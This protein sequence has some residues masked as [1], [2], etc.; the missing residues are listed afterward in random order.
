MPLKSPELF[1]CMLRNKLLSGSANRIST[2]TLRAPMSCSFS[3]NCAIRNRGHGHCPYSERL[4]VSMST[5]TILPGAVPPE[6][7]LSRES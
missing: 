6:R 4:L 5:M 2:P 3:T 1:F 7:D